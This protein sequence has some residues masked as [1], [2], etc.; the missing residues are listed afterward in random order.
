MLFCR[1]QPF[2]VR[3]TELS[4]LL[5]LKRASLM[6]IIQTNIEDGRIIMNNLF[7][8]YIQKLVGPLLKFYIKKVDL[9]GKEAYKLSMHLQKL[10]GMESLG[11]E[12]PCMN[13]GDYYSESLEEG[14]IGRS[15]SHDGCEDNKH[16]DAQMQEQK[17]IN[18]P[19]TYA[20]KQNKFCSDLC[21]GFAAH[22]KSMAED[23]ETAL[24]A[25]VSWGHLEMVKILLEKGANVNKPDA[26]GLTPKALAE[27]QGNRNI[28]ELLQRYEDRRKT[29]E[30]RIELSGP[31]IADY[32]G[33]CHIKC[34]N[35]GLPSNL[36]FH[37]QNASNSRNA[38]QPLNSSYFSNPSYSCMNNLTKKRA[39]IYLQSQDQ[40]ASKNKLGKVIILPDSISELLR[41]A[42]K[43]C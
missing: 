6:N 37:S 3:T 35:H 14:R 39:T 17:D 19:E 21:D 18:L 12:Y 36:S 25:A 28:Y 40:P 41:V 43:F 11:F 42:G 26:R 4:Q 1:P 30:H 34:R 9:L 2:T 33:N 15:C 5:R 29:D 23:G 27:Q 10:K 32:T 38:P 22:E 8:V 7:Q 13:H 31:E 20:T 24:H 16:A